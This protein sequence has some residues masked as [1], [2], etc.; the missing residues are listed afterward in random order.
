[1]APSKSAIYKIYN[2]GSRK[3]SPLKNTIKFLGFCQDKRIHKDILSRAPP[4]VIKRICDAALN[5]RQGQVTLSKK[6]K[7]VLAHHR[8]TI[9]QLLAKAIPVER[10]RKILVQRG[11][12]I[13]A[14]ILPVILSTVLGALG[15]KLFKK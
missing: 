12:G 15:S 5:A 9:E 7:Q 4:N 14:L 3:F 2:P 1:M 6:Q 11:G 10:K 8:K 13:A